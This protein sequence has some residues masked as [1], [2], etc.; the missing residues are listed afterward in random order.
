MLNATELLAV[1]LTI[2]YYHIKSKVLK[3]CKEHLQDIKLE[4]IIG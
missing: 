1:T 3:G 4:D 2:G